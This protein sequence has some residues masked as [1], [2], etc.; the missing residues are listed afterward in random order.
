MQ[1]NVPKQIRLPSGH[2][3]AYAEYGDPAGKPVFFLQGTPSSRLMHPDE[4]ISRELG[5]R[6]IVVDRPGFGH[7]DFQR[8]RRLLDWPEQLCAVA[9]ALGIGRFAVAG[10]S[11]GG[12]Y[13]L[14]CAYWIPQRLTAVAVVG[15]SAPMGAPGLTAG[16]TRERR[17][18]YFV[19]TRLPWLVQPLLWLT[20]NPRRDLHAFFKRYTADM[21]P[22]DR[23]MLAQTEF[24][25][26]MMRNYAEAT[27]A[28]LRGFAWEVVIVARPWGF[29][30]ED[31]AMDV[32]LWHGEFDTSTPLPMGRYMAQAL[33]HCRATFLPGEGHFV[34]FTHWR[35]IL[36]E[37]IA[38]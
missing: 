8:G 36:T 19:A 21:C 12:P 14:A 6:V 20:N 30:L 5:A 37:L 27:R 33:P 18:G 17:I 32:R 11:G 24:R 10:V 3:L 15:G 35:E 16:M 34:I 31:I 7:S 1:L 13:A 28:G 23:A 29:R 4:D 26:M 38:V 25:T 2:R 22:A 9:D